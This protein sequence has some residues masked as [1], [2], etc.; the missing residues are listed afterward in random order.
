MASDQGFHETSCERHR[1]HYDSEQADD[2]GEKWL[3]D[4]SVDAWHLDQLVK[5]ATVGRVLPH[6]ETQQNNV[7]RECIAVFGE[8][9]GVSRDCSAGQMDR[10][11]SKPETLRLW[12]GLHLVELQAEHVTL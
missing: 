3:N 5:Q 10:L 11:L 6:F 2:K 9:R 12:E 8:L 1:D 4:G 7:L